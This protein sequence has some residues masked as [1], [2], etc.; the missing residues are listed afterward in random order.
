MRAHDGRAAAP[1]GLQRC[2]AVS[3]SK[4]SVIFQR[5]IMSI[6]SGS[7]H[8]LLD[9]E[10]EGTTILQNATAH[11]IASHHI[12]EHLHVCVCV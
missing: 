12:H 7:N 8:K 9:L 5:I 11:N 10:D 1:A 4:Q 6:F 3:P 2:D